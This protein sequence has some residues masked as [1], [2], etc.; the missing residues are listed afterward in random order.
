MVLAWNPT[1]QG[2]KFEDTVLVKADGSLENLTPPLNWPSV[3]VT[4]GKDTYKVP[5]VK[6]RPMPE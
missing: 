5:V 6:V 1:V 2:T 4:V 3:S